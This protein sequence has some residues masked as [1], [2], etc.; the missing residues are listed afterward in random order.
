MKYKAVIF[1]LDGVIVSTDECHYL[2]WKKLSDEEGIEFDKE[3]NIKLRGVS[4]EESLEIILEKAERKYSKNEKEN[5]ATRKNDYYVE[6]VKKLDKS[7]IM[8][9]VLNILELLKKSG[10]KIAVG[11]SSRNAHIILSQI[12]LSGYFD[13]VVDGNQISKSKPDPE[14]FLK[15]AQG[16]NTEPEYCLVV[17]DADA[18]VESGI[19]AHMDVLAV[20]AASEN[21]KAKYRSKSLAAFNLNNID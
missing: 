12:G 3:I 10:V 16:L 11:S 5:L 15:A 20:G 6:M 18:G 4:R 2:A 1:D 17:E 7:A 9:G 21:P 19:K 14:V 13:M 8:E